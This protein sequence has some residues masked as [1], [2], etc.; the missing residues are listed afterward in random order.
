MTIK[1]IQEMNA[2]L[3]TEYVQLYIQKDS[4]VCHIHNP[5]AVVQLKLFRCNTKQYAVKNGNRF[6]KFTKGKKWYKCEHL[7][8]SNTDVWHIKQRTTNT[9][10]ATNRCT[11]M[12]A[13]YYY[14]YWTMFDQTTAPQIWRIFFWDIVS[15]NTMCL[16]L[17]LVN[18]DCVSSHLAGCTMHHRARHTRDINNQISLLP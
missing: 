15:S 8:H 18:V 5:L 10:N 13:K 2:A 1:P 17:K 4:N 16:N 12:C 11:I 3:T 9:S 6:E 14:Q 7:L